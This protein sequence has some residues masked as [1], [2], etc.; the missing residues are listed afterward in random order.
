MTD[1][2]DPLDDLASARLDGEHD[3]SDPLDDELRAR[4]ERLAAAR[5]ALRDAPAPADPARREQ[6][7]TAAL[8]AFDDETGRSERVVAALPARRR[9]PIRL[10]E[11]AG[12][13]AAIVALAL[14]VPLLDRLDSGSNDDVVAPTVQSSRDAAS[15]AGSADRMALDANGSA[16][17]L[18]AFP[19][20]GALTD[21][22][23]ARLDAPAGYAA[24]G[25]AAEGM[26][27]PA[28]SSTAPVCAD[29]RSSGGAEVFAASATLDGRRV[30]VVVLED[31]GGRT[32]VVLAS[33]DCSTVG[34]QR[35]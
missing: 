8:A 7:I 5:D 12:I 26:A 23:R 4:V 34:R 16:S 2:P 1:E 10:V 21:A 20:V 19:D 25:G 3:R 18:G 22:V 35:L 27:S 15:G 32:L 28:P 31:H 13:A 30:V 24:S 17:D 6:A 11:M 33:H 29:Q 9:R 14:V